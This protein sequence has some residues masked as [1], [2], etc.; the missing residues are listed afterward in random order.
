MR[1]AK[2]ARRITS[3][4]GWYMSPL[5]GWY[6]CLFEHLRSIRPLYF[7]GYGLL[8]QLFVLSIRAFQTYSKHA[9]AAGSL[10]VV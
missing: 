3:T 7:Q 10:M 5:W 2:G 6:L 8:D 1:R 9:T 4:L